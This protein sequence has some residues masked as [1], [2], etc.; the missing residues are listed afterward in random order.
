MANIVKKDAAKP[1][2]KERAKS[3][4]AG[5]FFSEL[6]KVSWPT[7]KE[8]VNYTLTVLAF[9]ALMAVIIGALDFLFAQGIS[10][11]AKL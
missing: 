11:L 3:R 1:D 6:K 2:K 4:K 9:V 10:L 8:M 7:P 5:K